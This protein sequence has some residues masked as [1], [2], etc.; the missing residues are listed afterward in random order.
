MS[1]PLPLTVLTIMADEGRR[2]ALDQT[3]QKAGFQCP[4]RHLR[5]GRAS[6]GGERCRMLSSSTSACPT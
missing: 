6:L 3:F 4:G 1:D 2:Y 5:G